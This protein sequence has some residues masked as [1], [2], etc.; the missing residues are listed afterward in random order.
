M[1]QLTVQELIEKLQS[2]PADF[3]VIAHENGSIYDSPV[4]NVIV[5]AYGVKHDN[6]Q[7]TIK[8]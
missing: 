6:K 4:T 2:L 7:V 8:F 5:S 1:K 3:K